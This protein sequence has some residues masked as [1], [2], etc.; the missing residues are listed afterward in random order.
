MEALETALEVHCA[1][2]GKF[3]Y[4]KDG[5]GISGISHSIC[6]ECTKE[7]EKTEP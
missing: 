7:L 4:V 3:M 2:C 1:W 6:P 5:K